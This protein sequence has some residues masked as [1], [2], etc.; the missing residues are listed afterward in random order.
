L[1]TALH[2]GRGRGESGWWC[3]VNSVK[4]YAQ[5]HPPPLPEHANT[6][7]RCKH[8]RTQTPIVG[9]DGLPTVAGLPPPLTVGNVYQQFSSVGEGR[10]F[11]IIQLSVPFLLEARRGVTFVVD[12]RC[13]AA[14]GGAPAGR[15]HAS[16][17]ASRLALAAATAHAPTLARARAHTHTH[18]H[19]QAHICATS[20]HAQLRRAQRPPHRHHL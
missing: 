18:T 10:V 6:H 1:A 9:L 7:P 15:V 8:A 19:H 20:S 16:A 3:A 12:A 2:H 5:C 13:G 11:N 4:A 14:G 17:H